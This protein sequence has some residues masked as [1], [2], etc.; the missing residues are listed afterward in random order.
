MCMNASLQLG[1]Q[2]TYT[3]I[4]TY[5][6]FS[7]PKHARADGRCCDNGPPPC[8]SKCD[9]RFTLCVRHAGQALPDVEDIQ[10][11]DCPLGLKFIETETFDNSDDIT[12][13]TFVPVLFTG[14]IWPVSSTYD[15]IQ[16]KSCMCNI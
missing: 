16:I 9:N 11:Q 3:F 8:S 7:N 6:S 15:L 1:C 14:D 12:F 10:F 5:H 13:N 2:A 4:Q